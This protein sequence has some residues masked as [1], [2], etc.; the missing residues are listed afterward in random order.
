MRAWD[1]KIKSLPR[2]RTNVRAKEEKYLRV[3]HDAG[4]ANYCCLLYKYRVIFFLPL[5]ALLSSGS[6]LLPS[7]GSLAL[8]L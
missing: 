1:K 7:L 6:L 8:A 2:S 4:Y 5:L 3:L